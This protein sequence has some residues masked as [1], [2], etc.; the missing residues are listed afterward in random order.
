M[1]GM[2]LGHYRVNEQLGRGGMGE[3]YIAD[4][5][6][7]NRKVALKFLPE[8]FAGD[9][10]R[11]ARFERE[12]RLLA[13][14]N[15]P[16]IAAI[17]GLEQSEGKRF[18]VM[19]LVEGETLAQRISKGALPV[20]EALAICRQIAEGLEAAHEK[21]VI[22][23]DLKPANVMITEGDKVKILDFGLAKALSDE[24]Q[25]IDSSQS[26]T[27]TE[28]MTRPGVILGTAAYMSPEQAKGKSVDKRA[29]I[30]AFGCILHECLTGKRAFD[31]ETVTETL[32]AVLTKEPE[33]EKVPARMR[34][35][36]RRCLEK[37]LSKRVRDIGE[38]MAWTENTP[39]AVDKKRAWPAWIFA[40][41]LM[42]AFVMLAFV[43]FREKPSAAVKPIHFQ[44][45]MPDKVSVSHESMYAV[46]PD[47]QLLALAA[48]GPDGVQRIWL[49]EIAS[50]ETRSLQGTEFTGLNSLIWSPDSRFLAFAAG[51]KLRKIAITGGPIKTLC[52]LP[53]QIMGGSWNRDGV[54]IFGCIGG[55]LM[56]IPDSGG[57]PTLLTRLN[58][59][60]LETGHGFPYFL[61]D[62]KHF[63][64]YSDAPPE[65][66]GVWAGSLDS[67]PEEQNPTEVL[68]GPLGIGYVPSADSG[69]GHLLFISDQILMAQEFDELRLK[70]TGDAVP[71]AKPVGTYLAYGLFS[72]S[73]GVLAYRADSGRFAQFPQL[74][75]FDR[76]GNPLGT[77]GDPG[78]YY[79]IS[80]F[81]S[82]K[83]AAVSRSQIGTGVDIWQLDL[84]RNTNSRLTFSKGFSTRPVCSPDGSRIIF[85][86][87][88]E[89]TYHLYRKLT[90]GT[91]EEELLLQSNEDNYP[92]SWSSDGRFLLYTAIDGNR[93]SDLWI[94]PLANDAK[95]IRLLHES[96]NLCD[97]QFSRDMRWIAYVSD[98][99]GRSE[100]YVRE[101]VQKP[102]TEPPVLGVKTLVS[103]EGGKGPRWR[104]DG[105]ELFFRA[106]DE[107]VMAVDIAP[108]KTFKPGIP[109]PL[110]KAPPDVGASFSIAAAFP[111]WDVA[112]DG[113][114]FLIPA[115][116][117][118][119]SASPFDIIMN[120]TSLLKK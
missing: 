91:A 46:S 86:S 70:L 26:P 37:D 64:Y 120:W 79:R 58:K 12:A 92:T 59:T 21:G 112:A 50:L 4:D 99:T 20:D 76:Q 18:I 103:R 5:L 54:I 45:M 81:D 48:T 43:H 49:R 32:A 35:L 63:L 109:K 44:L 88:R 72:A 80:L 15:H 118:E 75:W 38:A 93:R 67:R 74:T 101:F 87:N 71:L 10:E 61:R 89:G 39:D 41:V 23:R 17:Y 98:E 33:W 102:G 83:Q 94:L 107:T 100:I 62:G 60:R 97:A 90:G 73:S 85:N 9:S 28:A 6:N 84:L 40:A 96:F 22:H 25:S 66:R 7:L 110:F 114:R 55:G 108:G 53:A 116:A 14:L 24:A 36:L 3:V 52:D 119:G 82:D 77:V 95:P 117:S 47:G 51:G 106:P 8:A 111:V 34:P 65:K 57:V 29:D 78:I 56:R 13:S 16:N 113:E 105:K 2:T 30:W 115:R 68:T 42:A 27:L 31:G 104:S 19:E 69:P 11:M 1:I